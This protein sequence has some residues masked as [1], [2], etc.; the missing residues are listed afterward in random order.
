MDPLVDNTSSLSGYNY[1]HN[2]PIN[3]IDLFGLSRA[4]LAPYTMEPY[5][6]PNKYHPDNPCYCSI[7]NSTPAQGESTLYDGGTLPEVTVTASRLD[8]AVNHVAN[9]YYGGSVE[10]KAYL[11]N[12]RRDYPGSW[13]LSTRANDER[14]NPYVF[15]A[16]ELNNSA[17]V[18]LGITMM[19]IP[20]P[21]FGLGLNALKLGR[22]AGVGRVF[23][24]GGEEAMIAA[25][26]YAKSEGLTTLGM[27]RAGQNLQKLIMSKN[28]PWE[29]AR[30]MW[31]RLSR[32]YAMGASGTVHFFGK[33][34]PGSIF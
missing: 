8:P 15:T 29:E 12:L 26:E 11:T 34:N 20:V 7:A 3:G 14:F 27:A 17:D 19:F 30:P 24:S 32:M 10:S 33:I 25:T 22:T 21:K 5:E 13:F 23:W 16:Q 4:G 6:E 31:A 1:V 9:T 2:N 18:G 28:I